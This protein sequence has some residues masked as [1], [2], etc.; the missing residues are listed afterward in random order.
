MT[1]IICPTCER[2]VVELGWRGTAFIFLSQL[3]IFTI[4]AGIILYPTPE[5]WLAL[6]L[7]FYS[8]VVLGFG[9]IVYRAMVDATE[10]RAKMAR[11]RARLLGVR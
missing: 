10:S 4:F 8:L 11:F 2:K 6:G 5:P 9:Y 3:F 1:P 7:L